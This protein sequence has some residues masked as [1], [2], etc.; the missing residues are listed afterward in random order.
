MCSLVSSPR[1]EKLSCS[2]SFFVHSDSFN[3]EWSPGALGFQFIMDKN[4]T[5]VLTGMSLSLVCLNLALL[6]SSYCL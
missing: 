4:D 5:V 6:I 2:R 1:T 3:L